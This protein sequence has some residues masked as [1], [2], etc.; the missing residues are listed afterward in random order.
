MYSIIPAALIT[1]MYFASGISKIANFGSVSAGF[2]GKLPMPLLLANLVIALVILLE[3]FA[4]LAIVLKTRF[5][6]L[7]ARSLALFTVLATIL[8]HLPPTGANYYQFMSNVTAV[9]ALLLL[10]E[11]H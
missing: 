11:M 6:K 1:F 9:G 7:A 2:A 5:S 3:L 8:Y 10:G 4:P